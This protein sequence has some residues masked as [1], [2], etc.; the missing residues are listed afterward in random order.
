MIRSTRQNI[1]LSSIDATEVANGFNPFTGPVK[2][3]RGRTVLPPGA[4]VGV[5]QMGSMNWYVEG[6][7]GKVQ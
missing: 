5:D 4:T 1:D 6:V 7:V 2:D 3:N